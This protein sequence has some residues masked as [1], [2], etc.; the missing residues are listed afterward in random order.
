MLSSIGSA[1]T[2]GL[3]AVY[4]CLNKKDVD[5]TS[6]NWLPVAVVIVFQIVYQIGL[7][8]IPN[9]LIGE[10]FPTTVKGAAGAIVTI[11]DGLMGFVG[12]K[13]YQVISEKLGKDTVY[14][15]FSSSCA[16]LFFLTYFCIRET[17]N[18]SFF[19][20]QEMLSGGFKKKRTMRGEGD[21]C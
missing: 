21:V 19:E 1:I 16:L 15:F 2:L 4:L 12:S 10:L 14:F 18:K 9:A 7:G 6:F 13:L 8:T 17:R 20:I 5:L 11:V 3:L